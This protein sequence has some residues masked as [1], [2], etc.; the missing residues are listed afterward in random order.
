MCVFVFFVVGFFTCW[1]TSTTQ[2]YI[3]SITKNRKKTAYIHIYAD[4]THSLTS[5]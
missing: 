3:K 5:Y 4:N 1:K 2:S